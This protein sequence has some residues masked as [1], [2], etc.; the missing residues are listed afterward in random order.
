MSTGKPNVRIFVCGVF[1]LFHYGHMDFLRRAV[2]KI[3]TETKR[4][5][6]LV[7][8]VH[9]DSEVLT[10][11]RKPV[12]HTEER[13]RAVSMCRYVDEVIPN[14][15]YVMAEAM[16]SEFKTRHSIDITVACD[17]YDRVGNIFYAGPRQDGSLVYLPRTPDI[18]T[19]DI[20][21]RVQKS[22]VFKVE[23]Q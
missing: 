19:T 15:P 17:E 21:S 5:V 3:S 14:C 18:S 10:F 8:G 1:D 11:K 20:I 12:L 16:W 6:T 2:D 7:V 13:C 9:S 23:L 4:N 22:T